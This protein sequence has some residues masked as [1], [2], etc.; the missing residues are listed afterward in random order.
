MRAAEAT[1]EGALEV[2]TPAD[3]RG[4]KCEMTTKDS[5]RCGM[6]LACAEE[7]SCAHTAEQKQSDQALWSPEN[8]EW[9]QLS[10]TATFVDT[11][12]LN[13]AGLVPL[14]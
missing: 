14:K 5:S 8:H 3:W 9:I 13:C 4:Q 10:D 7:T 1:G 12:L 11:D 2:D 6:E